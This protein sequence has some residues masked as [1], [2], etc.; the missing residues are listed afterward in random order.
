MKF[1]AD[2][3]KR[4][5]SIKKAELK[6]EM[7]RQQA[8]KRENEKKYKLFGKNLEVISSKATAAALDGMGEVCLF[9]YTLLE[10]RDLHPEIYSILK[11]GGFE[12][13]KKISFKQQKLEIL[14]KIY[15]E[16]RELVEHEFEDEFDFALHEKN[17]GNDYV[18]E[19]KLLTEKLEAFNDF[20]HGNAPDIE[21]HMDICRLI[22]AFVETDIGWWR[23]EKWGVFLSWEKT[24]SMGRPTDFLASY[25]FHYLASSEG[26]GA[27][28]F[29]FQKLDEAVDD[30]K[31]SIDVDVSVSNDNFALE[32]SNGMNIIIKMRLQHFFQVL[33]IMGFNSSFRSSAESNVNKGTLSL[34]F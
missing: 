4:K 14:K 16:L 26:Q 18:L 31:T 23:T 8:A 5:L 13:I 9:E 7:E 6:M 3:L 21:M 30:L 22:D 34:G 25:N 20:Y 11:G 33:E 28:F 27:V 24:P 2:S 15:R 12:V 1:S 17:I 32:F 19:E 29:L 10:S